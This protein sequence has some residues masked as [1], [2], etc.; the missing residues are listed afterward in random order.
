MFVNERER[1]CV[2]ECARER[3][4]QQLLGLQYDY[5][6]LKTAGTGCLGK[7]VNVTTFSPVN[8]KSSLIE[9]APQLVAIT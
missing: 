9:L 2:R 3:E 8:T 6:E 1:E 7:N 5:L 4:R